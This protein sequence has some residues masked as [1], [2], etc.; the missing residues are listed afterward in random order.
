MAVRQLAAD[1]PSEPGSRA[2]RCFIA[3]N[4]KTNLETIR[5][6]LAERGIEATAS[7]ERPW[8]GAR[9]ID[10][11][12]ALIDRADLV[13]GVLDDPA[14]NTNLGFELGYAFARDKKIMVLLPRDARTVPTD[15]AWT[16]HIRA[17]PEDAEGIAYNIDAL[18]ASPEPRRQPYIPEEPETR[19]I[20]EMAEPLLERLSEALREHDSLAV[21]RIVLDAIRSS[22]VERVSAGTL[23]S[24]DSGFDLGIWSHDLESSV[25]NPLLVSVKLRISAWRQVRTLV[26]QVA[27]LA[28]LRS[29]DWVL[30]LVGDGPPEW[31]PTLEGE[32]P[33]LICGIRELVERLRSESF[34]AVIGSLRD[35]AIRAG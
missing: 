6:L 7:Y 18:L 19:P 33:V 23:T 25:G 3:A 5:A 20:G 11:I 30:L 29:V 10:T 28:R 15:L 8:I 21:E 9:P 14:S 24:P 1:Q 12:M 13:I 16:H 27:S 4:P 26:E 22:G 35:K 2:R 34:A 31:D 17:N 32:E